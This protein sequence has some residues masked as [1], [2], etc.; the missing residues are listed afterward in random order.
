[1]KKVWLTNFIINKEMSHL[2]TEDKPLQRD[3]IGLLKVNLKELGITGEPKVIGSNKE[4]GKQEYDI[5]INDLMIQVYVMQMEI[6]RIN[7]TADE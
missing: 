1:M 2:V 4:K 6:S 5:Q 3:V 7:W